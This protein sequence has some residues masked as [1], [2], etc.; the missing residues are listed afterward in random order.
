MAKALHPENIIFGI[1]LQ[2]NVEPNLDFISTQSRIIRFSKPN[3]DTNTGPGIIEIRN[4]IKKLHKD[5]EY[6][7]QI[8]AHTNFVN[9]WDD[10]LIHD[11]HEFENK[12]VISKQILQ[13]ELKEQT[14]SKYFFTPNSLPII[15]ASAIEDPE[16][17]KNN[18]IEKKYFYNY[19]ISGAF[20]FTKSKWLYEVPIPNYHKYP[21]EEEEQAL[22]SYCHGYDIV[23]PKYNR[24]V[25]FPGTDSKHLQPLDERWWH[26]E[27]IDTN[28]PSTWIYTRKWIKDDDEMISEVEKLFIF[29]KNN[30]IDLTYSARPISSFYSAIGLA[31]EYKQYFAELQGGSHSKTFLVTGYDS[32]QGQYEAKIRKADV[33]FKENNE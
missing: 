28:D 11:I 6:F 30:F 12:T 14:R 10:I 22:I 24:Q 17:I 20:I 25:V 27:K 4:A 29:G 26:I 7:L 31:K 9:N 8:D 5:E 18:S 13:Q 16:Y 21:Y 23:A 1:S 33:N 2:Y 32:K 3:Y 15:G 19:Y